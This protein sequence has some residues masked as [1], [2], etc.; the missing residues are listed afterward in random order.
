[1]KIAPAATMMMTDEQQLQVFK[2]IGSAIQDL[3]NNGWR[4]AACLMPPLGS[5][6]G[7][8][9]SKT[10]GQFLGVGM[11]NQNDSAL[12]SIALLIKYFIIQTGIEQTAVMELLKGALDSEPMRALADA[13]PAASIS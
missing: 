7:L 12:A 4:Y 9:P 2:L 3:E 13:L 11:V 1:M 6:L 8:D 10:G 5:N